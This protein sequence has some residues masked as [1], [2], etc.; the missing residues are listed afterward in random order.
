MIVRLLHF[1]SCFVKLLFTLNYFIIHVLTILSFSNSGVY[2]TLYF[3]MTPLNTFANR[4]DPDQAAPVRAA[5]SGSTLFA[6]GNIIYL[7]L[8]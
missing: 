6:N 8:H 7:I 1:E 5:R 2:L 4:A 3:I